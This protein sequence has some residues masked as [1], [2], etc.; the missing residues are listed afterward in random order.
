MGYSDK[1][2]E[3]EKGHEGK[4]KDAFQRQYGTISTAHNQRP[5][6]WDG[7]FSQRP[8]Q[9]GIMTSGNQTQG[10]CWPFPLREA[11]EHTF[12]SAQTIIFFRAFA[13]IR[14]CNAIFV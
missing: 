13:F 11:W 1:G 9:E 3:G 7:P 4:E 10:L 14:V 12:L 2:H 8:G 6:A 5:P